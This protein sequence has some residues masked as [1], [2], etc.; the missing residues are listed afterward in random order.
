MKT[1]AFLVAVF[2]TS[3]AFTYEG[4]PKKIEM[5]ISMGKTSFGHL[6]DISL[7]AFQV[8]SVQ[9]CRDWTE[10]SVTTKCKVKMNG[11]TPI[12]FQVGSQTYVAKTAYGYCNVSGLTFP[13]DI[14][15]DC[16]SVAALRLFNPSF[17]G[18]EIDI[19]FSNGYVDSATIYDESR[20]E[21]IPNNIV[22]LY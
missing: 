14:P 7:N 16:I 21:N 13:Q 12:T 11:N 4:Q 8:L 5:L 17:Y 10:R 3:T 22:E 15:N 20:R 6:S 18:S 2:L 19:G 1:F 9:D